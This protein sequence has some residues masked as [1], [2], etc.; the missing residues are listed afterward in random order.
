MSVLV[1]LGTAE[2]KKGEGASPPLFDCGV[3]VNYGVV[4]TASSM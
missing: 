2:K 3:I 4:T 1:I